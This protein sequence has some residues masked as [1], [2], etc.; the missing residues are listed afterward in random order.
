MESW[1]WREFQLKRLGYF[2]KEKDEWKKAR[3]TSYY[4]LVAT[5]AIDTRKMSIEKFMP[6]DSAQQSKGRISDAMKEAYAKAQ[7]N[8]LKEVNGSRT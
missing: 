2:R 3:M 1:T 8:Y 6:L 5:G 4:S 7:N